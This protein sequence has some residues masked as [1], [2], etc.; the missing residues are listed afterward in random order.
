VNFDF[1]EMTYGLKR[2]VTVIFSLAI[3]AVLEKHAIHMLFQCGRDKG[4]NELERK[5]ELTYNSF[6]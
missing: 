1:T 6:L 2:R 5:E 3:H 4:Y